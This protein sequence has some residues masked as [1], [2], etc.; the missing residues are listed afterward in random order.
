MKKKIVWGIVALVV[1]AAVALAVI[2]LPN[3]NK[4]DTDY[5]E[6][7]VLADTDQFR[8]AVTGYYPDYTGGNKVL[9]IKLH[10]E[11]RSDKVKV[12]NLVAY[13][14]M[15]E[16][17]S[18]Y[19]EETY[20]EIGSGKSAN[21]CAFYRGEDGQGYQKDELLEDMIVRIQ[22]SDINEDNEYILFDDQEYR[23][24]LKENK[25]KKL[26]W[27]EEKYKS[28]KTDTVLY[29]NGDVQITLKWTF[30]E[31]QDLHAFV[32]YDNHSD[33]NYSIIINQTYLN[34]CLVEPR[35]NNYQEV[36]AN[37]SESMDMRWGIDT[38]K[39]NYIEDVNEI[40]IDMDVFNDT[41]H[42]FDSVKVNYEIGSKNA[43]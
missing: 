38:L 27:P 25:V 39:F 40:T 33:D 41:K 32:V 4:T 14:Y 15:Q 37:T 28:D 17:Y 18:G 30:E 10:L 26:E 35:N 16:G 24:N 8:C 22:T 19:T 7:Q 42:D 36:L 21:I 1:I 43:D 6:Y 9:G 3:A 20:I 2:L 12:Y 34:G 31:D 11:N 5:K 29:K 23:V 13:P